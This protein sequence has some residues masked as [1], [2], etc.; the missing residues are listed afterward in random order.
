MNPFTFDP[1]PLPRPASAYQ[2]CIAAFET[3]FPSWF[4]ARSGED[5]L[6]DAKTVDE[7]VSA[8][9]LPPLAGVLVAAPAHAATARRLAEA[10]AVVVGHVADTLRPDAVTFDV[11]DAVPCPSLPATCE[12]G[13]ALRP[14]RGLVPGLG[15]VTV[16][17]RDIS[18]A[19]RTAAA[20][21]VEDDADP[22]RRSWP[23]AVRLSAGE[24]PRVAVPSAASLVGLRPPARDAFDVTVTTLRAAGVRVGS[25]D[26]TDCVRAWTAMPSTV[27]RGYD[28]LLVPLAATGPSLADLASAFDVAAVALPD[29]GPTGLGLL[30]RAFDDQVAIDVVGLLSGVQ[31]PTPYPSTG[32]ELV[33][34]GDYL[35]GQPRSGE[36]DALGARFTDFVVTA[37]RYRM[38]ALA[39]DPPRPGIVPVS[40]G[41]APLTA[42]RSLVSPAALGR[43]VAGLEAPML[44]GPVELGDGA[45]ATGVLCD[46]VG[47]AGGAD[48]T[49]F[50]CWRAYLRHRSACRPF[51]TR[52]PLA[53]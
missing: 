38:L 6:V 31:A 29:G 39:T 44:L 37:P 46:P 25:V 36:L 15:E 8:G 34:F 11:V 28:A 16:V 19:Q 30:T 13:V 4:T 10:G 23:D 48:V 9:A 45:T 2:R 1:E 49:E 5:V 17:A 41:G 51:S 3:G 22:A 24:H 47:A 32:V 26:L 21:T 33:V 12:R 18:V 42:E 53:A 40:E 43:F 14:T 52:P 27:L 20:L 7:R 50:G 35:R